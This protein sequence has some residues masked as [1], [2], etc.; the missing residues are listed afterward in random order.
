MPVR[1]MSQVFE[2]EDFVVFVIKQLTISESYINPLTY[3]RI[4]L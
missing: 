3:F 1:G 4:G 2:V